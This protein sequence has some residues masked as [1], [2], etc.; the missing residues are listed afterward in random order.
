MVLRGERIS[1]DPDLLDNIQ[2][3][4]ENG[5]NTKLLHS[6][7]AFSLLKALTEAGDIKAQRVF[8]EEIAERFNNGVESVREYLRSMD[9][10]RYLSLE[11][12]LSL[13]DNEN[14][15]DTLDRLRK[16]H[17]RF[18]KHE[19]IGKVLRLNLE[20]KQ[21]RVVKLDLRELELKQ[22]PD[23]LQSFTKLEHLIVSH[24]LLEDLPEWIGQF[25]FLK[26]LEIRSNAL[27]TLPIQIGDLKNLQELYARENRLEC[28][29]ESIGRLKSLNLFEL[30]NNNLKSLPESIG[31]LTSLR[32]LGLKK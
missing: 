2:V 14:D 5:Y 9:Y 16:D 24:N 13:I 4:Y 10:L 12:Y 28:L 7:L 22:I 6:N 15:R 25:R 32:I 18:E 8:K 1:N 17:P 27:K 3:W 29:P 19:L 26:K 23:Y 20:I 11:E 21:G 30:N 31:N